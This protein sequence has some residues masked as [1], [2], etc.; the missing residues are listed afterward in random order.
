MEIKKYIKDNW[1]TFTI[2]NETYNNMNIVDYI[3]IFSKNNKLGYVNISISELEKLYFSSRDDMNW[4][5]IWDNNE[6]YLARQ[7][8]IIINNKTYYNYGDYIKVNY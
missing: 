5:F 8:V 6:L 3:T 2:D 4:L 1:E 7:D